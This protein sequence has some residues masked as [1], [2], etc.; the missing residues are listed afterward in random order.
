MN[1]KE[2]PHSHKADKQDNYFCS[3]S[4]LGNVLE[5]SS[6]P[7]RTLLLAGMAMS[8]KVRGESV[9]QNAMVGMFM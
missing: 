6:A 7:Y 2:Y 4:T 1:N 8:T 9:S 5:A 3:T